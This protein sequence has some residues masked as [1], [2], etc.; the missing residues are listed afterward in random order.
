MSRTAIELLELHQL[1][2]TNTRIY[3]LDTFLNAQEALGHSE[4]EKALSNMDRITLYRTL[5][6]FEQKGVL[7]QALDTSGR[8]KYALCA[9]GC[10]EQSHNDHHAHF[11]CTNCDRT[12]CLENAITPLIKVPS[13][14]EI[15]Q[16]HLVVTGICENCQ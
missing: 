12:I 5:K 1:R 6:T 13:G 16:V 3:V 8:M 7:H 9:E 14:Y 11:H 4:L 10:S 15:E 2:K